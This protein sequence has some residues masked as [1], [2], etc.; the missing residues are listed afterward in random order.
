MFKDF[1]QYIKESVQ[2]KPDNL[3]QEICISMVLIN[4]TFLDNLLDKGTK[5]R[6]TEDSSVFLT[7]LKNLLIKKNR[8]KL[9]KFVDSVCVEDDNLSI[10]NSIFDSS[11]FSIENDW[12]KL[13]NSRN[14]ARSIIDKLLP[15]GKL[16]PEMIRSVF[17]IGPNKTEENKEDIVIETED[18]RQYSFFLNKN[19][20]STKSSSFNK[21]LDDLIGNNTDKLYK[22]E[23]YKMWNLLTRNWV[24]L[25][26]ENSK[27]EMREHINNFIISE[28]Q[29]KKID[30]FN[31]YKIEHRGDKFKHLGQYIQE[32]DK[33]IKTLHELLSN[34]WKKRDTLLLDPVRV[35]SEWKNIK[36][37]VLYSKIIENILT[38][39]IKLNPSNVIT[40]LENGF[41]SADGDIKMKLMKNIVDKLG[42]TEKFVYYISPNG[43]SLETIPNRDFFRKNYNDLSIEFDYHVNFNETLNDFFLFNIILKLKGE[44]LVSLRIE[45]DFSGSEMNNKLNAKYKFDLPKNFNYLVSSSL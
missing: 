39:N 27:D 13:I 44:E 9:G 31:Y 16:T 28:D 25:I 30:Y 38:S 36:N 7:D 35:E 19:M 15:D 6:Y 26:Y 18:G 43:D 17:F 37:R 21:L 29:I 20:N 10:V 3:V 22:D 33:N 41:K 45:V 1:N 2:Y 32:F 14:V 5:A 42:S 8:L 34:I 12:N 24:N 11:E 4:N 23:Y 40:R